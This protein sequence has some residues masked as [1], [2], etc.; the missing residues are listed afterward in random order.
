[1][2]YLLLC[3]SHQTWNIVSV[4]MNKEKLSKIGHLK[5]FKE[6]LNNILIFQKVKQLVKFLNWVEKSF[7]CGVVGPSKIKICED[8]RETES[9]ICKNCQKKLHHHKR[10]KTN[11]NELKKNHHMNMH[12]SYSF[13]TSSSFN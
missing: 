10:Q 11:M 12:I 4:K 13:L 7:D 2:V 9:G 1:M 3:S 8:C 6:Q 5:D